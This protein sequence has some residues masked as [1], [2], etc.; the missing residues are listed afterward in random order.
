MDSFD[1]INTSVIATFG[2]PVVYQQTGKPAAT[3][4]A[5]INEGVRMTETEQS[6]Y[7]HLFIRVADLADIAPRRGDRV[8]IGPKAYNVVEVQADQQ[9]GALL[10]VQG[11]GT[12]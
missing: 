11:R 5:V 1:A 12:A 8:T 2:D 9:G 6:P 10:R 4:K 7:L 3:I